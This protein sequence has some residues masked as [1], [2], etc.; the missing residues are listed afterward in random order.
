MLCEQCSHI[1]LDVTANDQEQSDEQVR[2]E[3]RTYASIWE[4]RD[5]ATTCDFCGL[6]YEEARDLETNET[7]SYCKQ[8]W[9]SKLT[10]YLLAHSSLHVYHVSAGLKHNTFI[11]CHLNAGHAPGYI[12]GPVQLEYK[13]HL[14]GLCVHSGEPTGH[15]QG[16][17]DKTN[18]L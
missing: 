13:Q 15:L 7:G 4:L 10:D 9:G 17:Y 3:I 2:A 14:G 8:K 11:Q 18:V 12:E 5:C 6:V 1:T 16:I